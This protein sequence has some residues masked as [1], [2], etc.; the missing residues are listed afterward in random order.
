MITKGEEIG[1]YYLVLAATHQNECVIENDLHALVALKLGLTGHCV[2]EVDESSQRLN[3]QGLSSLRNRVAELEG[4][5][6]ELKEKQQHRSQSEHPG[7]QDVAD[8]LNINA[9]NCPSSASALPSLRDLSDLTSPSVPYYSM[10]MPSSPSSTSHLDFISALTQDPHFGGCGDDVEMHHE[11]DS[12]SPVSSRHCNPSSTSSTG[13]LDFIS[14]LSHDPHFVGYGD[15]VEMHQL[16]STSPE[17]SHHCKPIQGIEQCSCVQDARNYQAMLELSVRLRKAVAILA[18]YPHHQAGR[19]CPLN[20]TLVELDT[21]TADSLSSDSPNHRVPSYSQTTT[22]PPPHAINTQSNL[23][24]LDLDTLFSSAG[25][26][27]LAS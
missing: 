14:A 17:S 19:Y 27:S 1:R 13:H 15:N 25:S 11:L 12:I 9:V 18:R 8:L 26:S 5:I 21:L 6:G 24:C 22:L 20:R 2:Y 23:T 7:Q 3:T 16:D 4:E 10:A